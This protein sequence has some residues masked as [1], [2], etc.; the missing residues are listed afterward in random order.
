MNKGKLLIA[1]FAGITLC[2]TASAESGKAAKYKWV[3]DKGRT[4]YSDT[5]PPE[6]ANKDRHLLNKS[7]VVIETQDVLT[8]DERRAHE[9]DL[10]KG[11]AV[12]AAARDQKL[13]DKSLIGTYSNVEEIELSRRRNIQQVEARINSITSQLKMANKSLLDFKNDAQNRTKAGGNIPESLV[14]DIKDA[15]A[16]VQMMQKDLDKYQQE[17]DSVNAR[18]DA[19]KQRYKELTGK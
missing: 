7:G 8:A 18:Y 17:K 11:K 6:Y 4:H 3:D 2:S 14:A 15:E 13:Y 9:A 10:A 5:I 16:R 1:L 19:D 12:E